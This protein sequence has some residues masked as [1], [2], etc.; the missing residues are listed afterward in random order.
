MSDKYKMHYDI[1]NETGE[2][3]DAGELE[4]TF[5]ELGERASELVYLAINKDSVDVKSDTAVIETLKD[6]M[7]SLA[8]STYTAG[9]AFDVYFSII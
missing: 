3:V 9:G 1:A 6:P 4:A 2:T 5:S 7:E 8:F